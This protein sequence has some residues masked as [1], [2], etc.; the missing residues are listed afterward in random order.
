MTTAHCGS[1]C[2]PRF[3]ICNNVPVVPPAVASSSIAASPS[4]S[5]AIA[6]PPAAS[7]S[8]SPS[9]VTN[10]LPLS[11]NGQCGAQ[12]QTSC[13]SACCSQYGWCDTT[14]AHCGA[15]CQSNFGTCTGGSSSFQPTSAPLP[16]N[17]PDLIPG[18]ATPYVMCTRNGLFALTLDDGPTEKVGD[19]LAVLKK[20][21][22]KATFFVNGQNRANL[23]TN[24]LSRALLK[25]AYTDG[26]Q[27]LGAYN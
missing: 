6:S 18:L 25:Q 15:G 27:V 14:S 16:S 5:P 23:A 9:P 7:P 2:Q 3:G 22:A 11:R 4:P 12:F 17:P 21:N 1:G 20:H 26:H 13:G 8:P 19:I 10:T 24:T